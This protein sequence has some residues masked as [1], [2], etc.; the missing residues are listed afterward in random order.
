[1][2]LKSREGTWSWGW[3]VKHEVKYCPAKPFPPHTNTWPTIV[4]QLKC[5]V[6]N[7]FQS[8]CNDG[9]IIVVKEIVTTSFLLVILFLAS[10]MLNLVIFGENCQVTFEG[11]R[12]RRKL[13]RGKAEGLRGGELA[14]V[15]ISA[16]KQTYCN[17]TPTSKPIEGSKIYANMQTYWRFTKQIRQQSNLWGVQM[18]QGVEQTGAALAF[19]PQ[20]IPED[21]PSVR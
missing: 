20:L 14:R 3:R 7:I 19:S 18:W 10:H 8:P 15:A 17:R 13:T 6:T 5:T 16:N 11:R 21:S 2:K 9:T 1:M 12:Q 4:E